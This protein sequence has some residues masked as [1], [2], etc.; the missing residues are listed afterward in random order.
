MASRIRPG[1]QRR[2]RAAEMQEARWARR[3]AGADIGHAC[4]CTVVVHRSARGLPAQVEGRRRRRI[5]RLVG[6]RH[7]AGRVA[8]RPEARV[9]ARLGLVGVDRKGVVVA[10]ARMRDVVRA[11]AERALRPACRPDRTRAAHGRRSS[12]AAR[13]AD[14]TRESARRPR[15]RRVRRSTRAADA[16]RCRP[17]N[18]AAPVIPVTLTCSRSTDEST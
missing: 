14:S 10:A 5:A 16:G 1:E 11:A 7:R 12:D 6:E 3:E 9:A 4:G 2:A 18:A 13:M 15:I 17:P 8:V